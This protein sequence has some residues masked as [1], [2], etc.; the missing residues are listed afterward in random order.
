MAQMNL[1]TNLVMGSVSRARFE[2][3]LK[4]GRTID[5][6]TR[7][8][9]KI[10]NYSYSTDLTINPYSEVSS[11]YN[12]DQVKA[13]TVNI[14]PLQVLQGFELDPSGQLSDEIGYQLA[15][16]IDQYTI[17]KALSRSYSTLAAG[18]LSASNTF[19]AF[20]QIYARLTNQRA[21]EGVRCVVAPPDLAM[22]LANTDKAN[23]FNL[24]D[25][26]LKNGYVGNTSA[27]FRVYVTQETPYSVTLS[28]PTNPTAGDTFSLKG[29]TWTFV[30]NGTAASAGEISI[31]GNAAATQAIVQ[32]AIN[33][34]GT[35]GA[36]TYIDFDE[37]TRFDLSNAQVACGNFS[38]NVATITSYGTC[39][40]TETFTA[41]GNV[42]GTNVGQVLFTVQNVIDLT[43]QSAPKI[44]I[45]Y[46]AAN[47]SYNM[48]GTSQFGSDVFY[49][50]RPSV[51]KMTFNT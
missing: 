23:G 38:A 39:S 28:L 6:P 49:L 14:D 9:V 45:R 37:N 17:S 2:P 3:D 12:I 4:P 47:V 40:P 33:G 31:G 15:R 26:T 41:T 36:S 30:A 42:F 22:L 10:Q 21:R 5:F 20:T 11:T 35:P 44:D 51:V 7:S 19:E 1:R 8:Q 29:Y 25:A 46:P 34:T 16:N 24:A 18:T 50:D 32:D 48:I 43:I 27:G 13:A